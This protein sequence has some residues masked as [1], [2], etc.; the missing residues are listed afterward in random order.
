[1]FKHLRLFPFLIGAVIGVIAVFFIKPQQDI[2]RKYPTPETAGKSVYRDKNGVCYK[3][4][5]NVVDCDKNELRLKDFP[6]EK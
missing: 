1:M 6:L 3:Y 5:A 2:V 4:N